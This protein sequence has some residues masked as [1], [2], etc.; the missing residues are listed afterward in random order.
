MTYALKQL[1]RGFEDYKELC[2]RNRYYVDKT[3]F[4]KKVFAEDDSKV[5][6]ITRPRRFGKTLT[7]S[8]FKYFLEL[9]H[10][11][12]GDVSLQQSLFKDKEIMQDKHFCAEFMG[13]YPVIFLSLKDIAGRNYG[14]ARNNLAILFAGLAQQFYELKK[15]E[16]LLP[17]QREIFDF[18]ISVV[19]LAENE[20]ILSTSLSSLLSMVYQY[21]GKQVVLLIDEYDVPLAKAEEYGYYDDMVKLMRVFLSSVLKTNNVLYKAVLTGCLR[22]SKE[23]IF[24]GVNNFSVNSV[25]SDL[26]NLSEC[27]GFT[28]EEVRNMLEYYGLEGYSNQVKHWYDGYRIANHELYCPW[29]VVNFCSDSCT[30]RQYGSKDIV[31]QNYWVGTSSNAVIK[32]YMPYLNEQ[33]AERM[34]RLLDGESI[35][36]AV[37]E[38]LNY[39]EIRLNHD[40]DDFWTL[41]LYTGYLTVVSIKKVNSMDLMCTARIPNE[42]IRSCFEQNVLSYYKTSPK[43]ESSARNIAQLLQAGE[44]DKAADAIESVLENYVSVRD[45][46]TRA[47]A[48]NYYHGFLNGLFSSCG[49]CIDDYRSNQEG[50]DGYAD[51]MFRT[52]DRATGVVLELKSVKNE[53][54]L[55]TQAAT[56]LKQITDKEYYQGFKKRSL[57][58]VYCYGIAFFR[59]ECSI[60]MK[61]LEVS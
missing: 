53:S 58:R 36:F 4:I 14:I 17:E 15:S 47:K 49:D 28:P 38:Q 1:P 6:L 31:C 3:A 19:K 44:A 37:N 11:K 55:D 48:E 26:G 35:E 56:A 24:T 45:F 8:M 40:A 16:L 18:L 9:N 46:A 10:E 51:I 59:K 61:T 32:E 7:M 25:I 43:I 27:I 34:Q 13:Q 22:V 2:E 50:G 42:E 39:N 52:K 20:S 21:F 57:K 29:D 23:S 30:A 41:L 60:E 33:E 12:P 5:L 54:E